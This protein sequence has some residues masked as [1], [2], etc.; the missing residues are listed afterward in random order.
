MAIPDVPARVAVSPSSGDDGRRIQAA[1]D[2]VTSLPLD[3]SGFRGAVLLRRGRFEIEGQ[4]RIRASGVVLRGSGFGEQGTTVVAT[5]ANRRTLLRVVRGGRLPDRGRT[6]R[7]HRD[8]RRE[9]DD[10]FATDISAD[11]VPAGALILPLASVEG[12]RPGDRIF[13]DRPSPREWIEQIG[14]DAFGVGWRPGTRDLRW[15]RTVHSIDGHRVTLDAPITTALDAALGGGRVRAYDWPGR[16]ENVG[17]EHLRFESEVRPARPLSEEHSWIAITMESVRD[18]WVRQVEFVQFAGGAV[19]LLETTS[20]VTVEDC[21]S[22]DP[23]SEIGGA[24]R[25][26]FF[27]LGQQHLFHRCWSERG[28]E[29]SPSGTA[30]RP[31]C[32]RVVHGE[33]GARRQRSDRELGVGSALRQRAHRRGRLCLENR[34]SAGQGAGWSA[35]NSVVWQSTASEIRC[36]T[37]P[38]ANQWA[39]GVWAIFRGNARW[40]A[41]N[42]FVQPRSLFLGQ[43]RDRRGPSAVASRGPLVDYPKGSDGPDPRTSRGNG[44]EL[45]HAGPHGARSHPNGPGALA[46]FRWTQT[47]RSTPPT[48]RCRPR[49]RR[50]EHAASPSSAAGS[51]WTGDSRSGE[52]SSRCGGA[53]TRVPPEREKFGYCLTRFSPG[54]VGIGATDDLGEVVDQPALERIRDPGASLRTL[55]RPPA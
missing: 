15:D 43:L 31:Q 3:A 7:G 44:G 41:R 9:S 24:R 19:H 6:N 53:A 51:S 45:V 29:T 17:I 32:V 36:F 35:A 55:V 52:R 40:E 18:A 25:R 14:M 42:S 12:L 37:P 46:D 21:A 50:T 16:L 11:Y 47:K 13:V 22:F 39:Y 2:Y 27:T 30:P 5:G 54:R 34:W 1:I 23:V 49:R 38:G 10:A 48:F 26:T 33:R 28:I 4:L 8:R 20:R